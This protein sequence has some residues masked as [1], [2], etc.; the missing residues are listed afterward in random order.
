MVM[1]ISL[2]LIE[3]LDVFGGVTRVE[4]A[5]LLPRVEDLQVKLGQYVVREGEAPSFIIVLQGSFEITKSLGPME[6]VIATRAPGEFFGEISLMFGASSNAGLR[7][8]KDGRALR[9]DAVDFRAL[10]H[11]SPAFA[12]RVRTRL[13]DK[14]DGLFEFATAAPPAAVIITGDRDD[15]ACRKL[16][17]FLALNQVSFEFIDSADPAL[18]ELMPE[19]DGQL[20]RLPLV[21][22]CDGSLLVAPSLP[23]LAHHLRMQTQPRLPEYDVAI[24]GEGPAAFAAS[25]CGSSEGLRTIV[26]ERE[27]PDSEPAFQDLSPTTCAY[28]SRLAADAGAEVVVTREVVAIRPGGSLHEIVLDGGDVVRAHAILLAPDDDERRNWLPPQVAR[29]PDGYV[30]TGFQM[31][32]AAPERWPLQREPFFFETSIPGIFAAGDGR[33]Q[34]SKRITAEVGESSMAI[35]LVHEYLKPQELVARCLDFA[36]EAFAVPG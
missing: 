2:E 33:S 8:A 27:R 11:A 31:L 28:S 18:A 20:S 9:I 14:I 22:V 36:P 16:R 19:A 29:D 1:M 21:Q 10:L 17:H 3:A 7:A 32:L 6:R 26:L 24:V 25:V 15:G 23:E 4:I 5:H 30:L 35:A 13:Y 12:Q 34:W